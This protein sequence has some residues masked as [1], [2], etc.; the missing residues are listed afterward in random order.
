MRALTVKQPWASLIFQWGKDI[1][2]R[3]WALP[4]WMK[5]QRVAIHSSK[6]FEGEEYDAAMA[7]VYKRGLPNFDVT[8]LDMPLGCILG[9]VLLADCVTASESP[10]FVGTY[11]SC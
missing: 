7:L 1:E 6:R 11:G 2:N 4:S 5:G 3:D 10:W 9:T 8:P